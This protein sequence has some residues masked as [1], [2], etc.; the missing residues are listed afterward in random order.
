VTIGGLGAMEPP[1]FLIEAIRT[2]VSGD[3]AFQRWLYRKGQETARGALS[4]GGGKKAP[5]AP[6]P[7]MTEIVS[8]VLGPFTRGLEDAATTRV[9]PMAVGALGL[10]GLLGYL[11]GRRR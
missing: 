8:P 7:W 5:A 6:S 10:A 3:P 1:G 9:L 4:F 11:V 2:S